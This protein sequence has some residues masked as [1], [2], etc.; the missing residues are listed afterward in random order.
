MT[1]GGMVGA[2]TSGKLA[3]IVGRKYVSFLHDQIIIFR[4]SVECF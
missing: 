3:N 4:T 2:V 1:I